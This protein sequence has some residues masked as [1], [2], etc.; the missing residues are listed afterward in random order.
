[1]VMTQRLGVGIVGLGPRWQRYGPALARLQRTYAIRAIFDPIVRRAEAVARQAGAAVTAGTLE[2]IER[3]DV[4]AVL[5]LEQHWFGLWPVERACALRKPVFSAVPLMADAEHAERLRAEV[6][7]AGQPVL[8]AHPLACAPALDRLRQLLAGPLGPARLVRAEAQVRSGEAGAAA[9]LQ[10][11]AAAALAAACTELVGAA[12]GDVALAGAAGGLT[13][14]FFD[15][16]DGRAVQINLCAA[17]AGGRP[18][19][20]EVA[21]AHGTA[22]ALPPARLGWRDAAGEHAQRWPR[23]PVEDGLL[24]RFAQAVETGQPAEPG[25][26]EAWQALSWL[27]TAQRGLPVQPPTVAVPA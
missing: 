26:E 22:W 7:A 27:R 24:L 2:L 20:I 12:A 11:P 17:P 19:R 23:S 15:L 4:Q 13:T 1:M 3:A 25:I 8:M 16:G 5:L 21:A 9:L 10:S 18:Y 14:A 6:T